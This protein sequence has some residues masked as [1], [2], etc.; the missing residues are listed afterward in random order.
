[1]VCV[2]LITRRRVGEWKKH[3]WPMSMVSCFMAVFIVVLSNHQ[4]HRAWQCSVVTSCTS[5]L[6]QK[7]FEHSILD[8]TWFMYFSNIVTSWVTLPPWIRPDRRDPLQ[9][10]PC[11]CFAAVHLKQEDNS[12]AS[13]PVYYCRICEDATSHQLIVYAVWQTGDA[14]PIKNGL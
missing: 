2:R 3:G 1:M 5:F 6:W 11:L 14:S 4:S 12:K 9:P 7:L 10:Q 13:L 8:F